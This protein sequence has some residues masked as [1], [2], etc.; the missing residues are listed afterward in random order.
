MP[1]LLQFSLFAEIWTLRLPHTL[2]TRVST[3][4]I[5]WATAIEISVCNSYLQASLPELDF[6]LQQSTSICK[7]TQKRLNHVSRMKTSDTQNNSLTTDPSEEKDLN[8]SYRDY[9]TDTVVRPE[10]AICRSNFVTRR[11]RKLLTNR[12]ILLSYC[13]TR[14]VQLMSHAL[15]L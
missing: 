10:Q 15:H 4:D 12:R 9:K 8:D 14:L 1:I 2:T 11:R 5:V 6:I 7:S 13:V 3:P